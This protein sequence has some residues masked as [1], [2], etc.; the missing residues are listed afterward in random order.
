MSSAA[1]GRFGRIKGPK[2]QK[3]VAGDGQGYASGVQLKSALANQLTQLEEGVDMTGT[4]GRQR[5]ARAQK[6]LCSSGLQD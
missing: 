6:G 3:K 5:R 4:F 2:D 1:D